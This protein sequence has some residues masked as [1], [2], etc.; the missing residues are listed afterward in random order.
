[1]HRNWVKGQQ[2]TGATALG[3]LFFILLRTTHV[4]LLKYR[5]QAAG[6]G[7]CLI[8][9]DKASLKM[10]LGKHIISTVELPNFPWNPEGA[11]YCWRG[12]EDGA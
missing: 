10:R 3:T 12:T 1:M 8:K 7:S 5:P 11:V 9:P 6:D 2:S 4:S